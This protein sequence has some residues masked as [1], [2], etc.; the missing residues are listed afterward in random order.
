MADI[1]L[2]TTPGCQ[3]CAR[4]KEWLRDQ[5]C[6]FDEL[7]ITGDVEALRE[8]REL[9]GGAGVPVIAH[10][11]DIVIGFDAHRLEGFV[12]SCENTTRVE[13]AEV[14]GS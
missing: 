6:E 10:G 5:G 13:A 7:D 14:A 9:S 1:K 8:W 12:S 3:H 11:G 4:A 2:Y